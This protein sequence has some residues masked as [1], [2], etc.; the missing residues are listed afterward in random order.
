M[1]GT[2]SESCMK[3]YSNVT[4]VSC[5]PGALADGLFA[6]WHWCTLL[7]HRLYPTCVRPS[8]LS[9]NFCSSSFQP[10]PSSLWETIDHSSHQYDSQRSSPS[11]KVGECYWLT[12]CLGQTN[13][14]MTKVDE[15]RPPVKSHP[16]SSPSRSYL[17]NTERNNGPDVLSHPVVFAPVAAS[18]SSLGIPGT[19]AGYAIFAGGMSSHLQSPS[20]SYF[21]N[22]E[23]NRGPDVLSHPVVF[24]PVMTALSWQW[25]VHPPLRLVALIGKCSGERLVHETC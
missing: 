23:P 3:L 2:V 24:V 7:V 1:Y 19:I 15:A 25:I 16:M 11:Y 21:V 14:K 5:H 12:P 13:F 9:G 20:K 17:V 22:T 6:T 4:D 18:L 10:R 8:L